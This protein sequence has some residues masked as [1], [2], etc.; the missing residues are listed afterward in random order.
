MMKKTVTIVC[1]AAL[2]LASVSCNLIKKGSKDAAAPVVAEVLPKVS[3]EA[4]TMR[5]VPQEGIYTSTVEANVIN[6]IAPQSALRIKTINVEIGDFVHEGK[7][8]A[9]MDVASLEQTKLQLI[10]DSTEL[11]R[12]KSLYEVGGVSKSDLDAITLSYNVRKT[13]YKNLLENTVL[14]SPISGVV[15][16][17]NYDVGDMYTMGKPIFTVEQ[18]TPVKLL[19]AV[20][21][22]DYTK[23]S[24]GDSVNLTV[25]AFP[26]LT[27]TGRI[28][29]IY[30]TIDPATHTFQVEVQV[31]NNYKTLRPGMYARVKIGFGKNHSVIAPD[32]AVVKQQGSGDKYMYV[33]NEADSTVV[34]TKVTLG[35][36]MGTEY[37]ILEGLKEG[38]KVVTEGLLRIK[39]GVKVEYTEE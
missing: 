32:R 10:N 37:E 5:D 35:V 11:A 30:P 3:V 12:I 15:T 22:K 36:R 9:K 4:V 39:D 19:V 29:R 7:V 18:I 6:N 38:D 1:F 21:E 26:D 34:M 8:L 23:V 28:A 16:A 14:R 2:A 25:D 27:F 24:K 33:L 13:T 20:S 17:R 31:A